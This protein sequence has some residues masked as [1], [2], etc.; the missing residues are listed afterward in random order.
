MLPVG[1]G[2]RELPDGAGVSAG[3]NRGS[4][5]SSFGFGAA[6]ELSALWPISGSDGAHV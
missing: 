1:G 3:E 2:V 5:F 6:G 4:T